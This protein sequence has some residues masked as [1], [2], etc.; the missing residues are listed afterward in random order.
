MGQSSGSASVVSFSFPMII[1]V[2]SGLLIVMVTTTCVLAATACLRSGQ[3]VR[4]QYIQV[5]SVQIML[6]LYDINF[7]CFLQ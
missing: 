6:L 7:Y 3:K 5:V 1:M 4:I 2:R